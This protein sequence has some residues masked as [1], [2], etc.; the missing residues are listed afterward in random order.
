M[1]KPLLSDDL[2]AV[3]EPLLPSEPPKPKGGRPRVPDRAALTGIL[4]VLR[5]GIPWEMLPPTPPRGGGRWAADRACP[6]GAGCATGT[7]RASGGRSTTPCSTG[8]ASRARSTGRAPRSTRK[9]SRLR[10]PQKGGSSPRTRHR[11]EPDRSLETGHEAPCCGRPTR[12]AARLLPDGCQHQRLDGSRATARRHPFN[13]PAARASS[14]ASGGAPRR[15][16]LRLPEVP[17]GAEPS[18]D[19][20]ADCAPRCGVVGALG[21]PPMGGGADA[22]VAERAAPAS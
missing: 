16:G 14:T 2:W 21:S 10:A 9:R 17:P 12:H 6:A 13:S 5:S 15:Q 11:A 18:S 3:V 20:G 7:R 8:S 22:V 4:F 1:A 19:Q